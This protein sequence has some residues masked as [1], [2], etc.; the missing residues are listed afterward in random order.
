MCYFPAQS[1]L[2]DL[3]YLFILPMLYWLQAIRIK[4]LPASIIPV[5]LGFSYAY[6]TTGEF[7]QLAF[8]LTL[9]SVLLIQIITNLFN[10]LMDHYQGA[11]TAQRLGPKR[12]AASGKISPRSLLIVSLS[13]LILTLIPGYLLSQI[14]GWLVIPIGIASLILSYGY[15]GKPIALAYR[16]LGEI[17]VFFFFGIL[18]T[19]GSAWI[20]TGIWYSSIL[21]LGASIGGLSCLLITINNLRDIDEDT[22]SE[23]R[24]LIVKLGWE[25]ARFLPLIIWT[26]IYLLTLVGIVK[27]EL[28]MYHIIFFIPIA[29]LG[30]MI[31][32]KVCKLKPSVTH[33]RYLALSALHL[34]L[35][36]I[37]WTY[38]FVI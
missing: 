15:T 11:D 26:S 1:R 22:Q 25:K 21:W 36:G 33:N 13:L 9:I 24:T 4:T 2:S 8:I 16:G 29:I 19:L 18:A 32:F 17:F 6:S 5:I 34:L 23:K 20:Q 14:R 35:Y 38:I 31:A 7:S 27:F 3:H 37:F 28:T 12:M 30:F 10:D